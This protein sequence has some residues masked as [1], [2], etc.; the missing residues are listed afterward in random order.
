M[1]VAFYGRLAQAVQDCCAL[2][3]VLIQHQHGDV[4]L[5]LCKRLQ[6]AGRP[7]GAA[8]DHDPD[9]SPMTQCFMHRI[10]Y[11]PAGVITRNENKMSRR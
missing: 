5:T 3:G 6:L 1:R 4:W 9:R 11:L 2:S 10:D 7:I 8:I